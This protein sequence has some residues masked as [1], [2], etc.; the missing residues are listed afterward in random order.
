MRS[1]RTSDRDLAVRVRRR[2][3]VYVQG[4]DPRGLAQYYRMFR[5]EL[6]KFAA[7][8][9]VK[10]GITRPELS[11]DNARARWHIDTHATEWNVETTYD[12]LR[13]EDVIAKDFSRPRPWVIARS[14]LIFAR[15]I[16]GGLLF[17]FFRAQWRFALFMIYPFVIFLASAAVYYLIGQC[18]ASASAPLG[19]PGWLATMCGW[20]VAL[21]LL[22]AFVKWGE[23]YTY[24]LYLMND[25]ISTYQ[26]AHGWRKDWDERI[27]LFARHLVEAAKHSDA[28]ELIVIGHSSGSFLAVSVLAQA[29]HLDPDL[30]G[31][32]PRVRLLTLGGNLP[33]VGFVP[34]AGWF[35]DQLRRLAAEPTIDWV[36]YQAR[37][38]VMN[39][40]AFDPIKGH[41]IDVGAA[42]RN[43]IQARMR[44]RKLIDPKIY[45]VFRWRF[46][47]VH[48]QFIMAND[49]PD[50]YDFFMML[51]GPID[52]ISRVRAPQDACDAL[53]ADGEARAQ[54]WRNLRLS[55]PF[56][57]GSASPA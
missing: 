8:Y 15:L 49:R 5:T 31:H 36:D 21:A 33:I 4:Y 34:A 3:I 38:D 52:L 17:R 45:P 14:F 35:R 2:H 10:S 30:G 13:W 57:K 39:F 55:E 44:L 22:V 51:C 41:G 24:M 1:A 6:R 37:K 19:M 27:T 20:I 32:K 47:R 12:F 48:F 18:A 56:A 53:A 42:R 43:P 11:D 23:R 29:L 16:F 46:F 25:T 50:A 9:D 54:A 40:F 28:D 26:F 7:L